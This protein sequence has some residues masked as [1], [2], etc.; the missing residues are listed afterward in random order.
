MPHTTI[1]RCLQQTTYGI[2]LMVTRP[3]NGGF[4]H[5]FVFAGAFVPFSNFLYHHLRIV[6]QNVRKGFLFQ[7]IFPKVCRSYAVGIDGISSTTVHT[8]VKWQK[9][10]RFPRKPSTH[11]D[12]VVVNG[13]MHRTAFRSQQR[14]FGVA[15]GLIL[16]H[17]IFDSLSCI[18]V[19]QLQRNDGQTVQ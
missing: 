2:Q 3:Y 14:V 10:R 12:V 8:L 9:P 16:F 18:V 1:F 17:S 7:D 5:L 4:C 19:F 15:V 6:F 13:E 11:L